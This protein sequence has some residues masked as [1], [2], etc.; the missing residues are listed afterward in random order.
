MIVPGVVPTPTPPL[1]VS[2]S[3]ITLA[4]DRGTTQVTVG[5]S[6][7]VRL[8]EPPAFAGRMSA[9]WQL[10]VA[11]PTILEEVPNAAAPPDAQGVYRA[12]NSGTTTLYAVGGHEMLAQ[13]Q[14][15]CSRTG[16][17]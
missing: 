8:A 12:I 16:F 6:F 11:D 3:E 9:T 14:I 7:V 2:P 10:S 5:A 17:P 13:A 15:P 1:L 4:D